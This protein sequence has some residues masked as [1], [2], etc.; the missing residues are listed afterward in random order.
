MVVLKEIH[1]EGAPFYSA[2]LKLGLKIAS[3]IF[4]IFF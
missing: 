3:P 2:K 4:F 1:P